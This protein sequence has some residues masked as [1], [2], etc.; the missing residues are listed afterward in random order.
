MS[1]VDIVVISHDFFRTQRSST[2]TI[3]SHIL[4]SIIECDCFNE[5]KSIELYNSQFKNK[6]TTHHSTKSYHKSNPNAKKLNG[7]KTEK[8]IMA[9]LNILNQSNKQI[10]HHKLSKILQLNSEPINLIRFILEKAVA[11][12][13]YMYLYIDI[14][15]NIQSV[16]KNIC[17]DVQKTFS[18]K[19]VRSL[20]ETLTE[21]ASIDYDDVDGF[22]AFNK[23]KMRILNTHNGILY[24]KTVN[25]NDYFDMIT[26]LFDL[27]NQKHIIDVIVTM[28]CTMI[29]TVKNKV[30]LDQFMDLCNRD[31]FVNSCNTKTRFTLERFK[32]KVDV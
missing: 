7:N 19:F 6:T 24:M 14:I 27:H 10:V 17:I 22:C 16:P 30:M 26:S 12:T 32:P 15:N 13:P 23:L 31:G 18:E 11:N 28:S 9:C 4:Q 2:N 29:D 5:Q 3:S 20:R 21:L 8:E 25:Q 1:N